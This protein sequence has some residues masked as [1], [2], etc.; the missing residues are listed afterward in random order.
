MV[1]SQPLSFSTCKMGMIQATLTKTW[2]DWMKC[3]EIIYG[4]LLPSPP[5]SPLLLALGF[6]SWCGGGRKHGEACEAGLWPHILMLVP[7]PPCPPGH[8][9]LSSLPFSPRSA[10]PHPPPCKACPFHVHISYTH[11]HHL[12]GE[13]CVPCVTNAD[14]F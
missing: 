7:L 13:S 4:P 6:P 10:P 8:V 3:N 14:T 5:P 11:F 9:V 1:W 2:Q 12:G